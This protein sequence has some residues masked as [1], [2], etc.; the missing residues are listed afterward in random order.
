MGDGYF[1]SGFAVDEFQQ[2]EVLAFVG[3]NRYDAVRRDASKD[4]V[5]ITEDAARLYSDVPP[6]QRTARLEWQELTDVSQGAVHA[7]TSHS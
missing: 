7:Y 2:P 5:H 1:G 6:V 4:T 3:D